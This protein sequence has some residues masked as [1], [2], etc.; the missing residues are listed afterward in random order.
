MDVSVLGQHSEQLF[1]ICSSAQWVQSNKRFLVVTAAGS[2]TAYRGL[3]EGD[4][5]EPGV[6][7][8][9]DVAVR[10]LEK[11]LNEQDSPPQRE[12]TLPPVVVGKTVGGVR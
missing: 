12:L 5:P 1:Q 10:E 8:P 9:I 3:T 7:F 6:V 4:F 11:Q 2:V